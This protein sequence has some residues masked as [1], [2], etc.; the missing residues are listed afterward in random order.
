MS[1]SGKKLWILFL[2]Y[3]KELIP[4]WVTRV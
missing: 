3:K 4:A 1:E 2:L